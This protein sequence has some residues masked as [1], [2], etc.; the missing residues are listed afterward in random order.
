MKPTPMTHADTLTGHRY[1]VIMAGGTG[2]RL[3]PL[4]R[5]ARPKQFQAFTSEKTLIQETFDRAATTVPAAQIFVSTGQKYTD[6]TREQLPLI[7]PEQLI[8]EPLAKNTAPAIIYIAAIMAARDPEAI[9][10]TIASDHAIENPEE[11]TRA[12]DLAFQTA[13]THP[14]ALITIGINPTRPDTNYGYIRMGEELTLSGTDRVFRI[15]NFKEKPDQATA[16]EYLASWEYLWNAGYFIFRASSLLAWIDT[17]AP[18]LSDFTRS[19]TTALKADSL[20]DE[21]LTEIFSAVDS[22][23]IDTVLA[24][25]LPKEQRFVVPSALK[26]SDVGGWHT[27]YEFLSERH[28]SSEVIRGQ[29]IDLDSKNCFIHGDKRLI[30]TAGLK[31]IVVIDTDDALLIADRETLSRDMKKLLATLPPEQR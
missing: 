8:I 9:I 4:S 18:E 14:D 25:R 6:L 3:W 28:L 17:Y 16:E 27:L 5:V 23:P 11:F 30:V 15:E 24:E 1:T 22:L 13:E 26:W 7:T 31:D 19:I 10:A 12:I 20:S 29:H 2:T 21:K